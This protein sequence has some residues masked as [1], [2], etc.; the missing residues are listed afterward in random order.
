MVNWSAVETLRQQRQKARE[1]VPIELLCRGH[2]PKHGAEFRF[3]LEDSA[4]KE[5]ID[6][7]PSLAEHAPV[8]C[9]LRPLDRKNEIVRRLLCPFAKARRL[10]C[11]VKGAVDFDRGQLA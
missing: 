8:R 1:V 9:K 3:Q 10:L 4:G 7:F 2:L 5:A 11:T 6:R